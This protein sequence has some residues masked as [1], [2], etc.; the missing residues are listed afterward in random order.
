MTKYI[1]HLC[2]SLLI[3]CCLSSCIETETKNKAT[4]EINP[5]AQGFNIEGSDQKAIDLADQVMEAMGGRKAYD[6]ARYFS[7][8]F[9]G[10][11]KHV[12]DKETGD[13][14]IKNLRDKYELHM[15]INDM[16]GQM[17]VGGMETV[18][19]DTL[20]KYLE[21]GKSM[22]IN[23]SYWLVMPFKLKDSGV[24]LKYLGDTETAEGKAADKLSLTFEH[25]GKTPENKYHVYVDKKS[26]LIT[27]WDFFNDAADPEPRFSTP[28]EGY[29]D[30]NGIKLSGGR[31]KNALSEIEVSEDLKSYFQ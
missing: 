9:F 16:T 17:I 19:L 1:L 3:V 11:R 7:W 24:T 28:W 18:N 2:S 8:N 15:N 23:D 13:V 14:Y 30:Y 12:W 4:T 25:V 21:K 20:G 26:K 6:N 5:P 22:W 29:K 31:G 10:S 27:Q